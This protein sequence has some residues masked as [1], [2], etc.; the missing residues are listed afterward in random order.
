MQTGSTTWRLADARD[1]LAGK[2]ARMAEICDN[3]EQNV[4]AL[5]ENLAAAQSNAMPRALTQRI[6]ALRTHQTW[7][8]F[9]T[10]TETGWHMRRALEQAEDGEPQAIVA[11]ISNA[12]A[13]YEPV[14]GGAVIDRAL[15]GELVKQS[16]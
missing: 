15:V 11:C 14:I 2:A 16:Q 10:P 8:D 12:F 3:L 1:Y 4:E 9:T 7:I 5:R 13:A 6:T